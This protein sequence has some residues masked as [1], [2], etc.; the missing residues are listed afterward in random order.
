MYADKR[1]I[2]VDEP[3][4]CQNMERQSFSGGYD[5]SYAQNPI[6][7]GVLLLCKEYVGDPILHDC[8]KNH[9]ELP[10]YLVEDHHEPLVDEDTWKKV[11]ERTEQ[12]R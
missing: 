2:K 10:L 1:H 4:R 8:H 7:T 6:Y 11:Q 5:Q 12:N 9:G 3:D